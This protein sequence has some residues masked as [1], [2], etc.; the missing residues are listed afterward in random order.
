MNRK[1]FLRFSRKKH[2]ISLGGSGW[3]SSRHGLETIGVA[4]GRY[5]SEKKG[6]A[7][8]NKKALYKYK[9]KEYIGNN[10]VLVNKSLKL[11]RPHKRR[12]GGL[13]YRIIQSKAPLTTWKKYRKYKLSH[14]PKNDM[15]Y[16]T[17]YGGKR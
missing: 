4:S 13:D 2:S 10:V 1:E 6:F 8:R 15:F 5:N 16:L 12:G 14:N 11:S 3:S 17:A 7:V 9:G